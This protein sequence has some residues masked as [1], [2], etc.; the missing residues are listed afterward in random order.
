[1]RRPQ[2]GAEVFA[3]QGEIDRGLEEAELLARVVSRAFELVAQ[4]ASTRAQGAQ[5]VG[6]LNLAALVA[7]G[8]GEVLEDVWGQDVA[9]HDGEI[10]RRVLALW[11]LHQFLKQIDARVVDVT[12]APD[13]AVG[14]DIGEGDLE[15][16]DHGIAG[17]FEHF[18][19]LPQRRFLRSV[20]EVVG[21]HHRER[22]I[23]H[24]VAGGQHG[25]AEPEGLLLAHVGN[26]SKIRNLAR[27][28][29]QI[30]FA[31]FAQG[32]FKLVGDV[33]MILHRRL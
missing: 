11:L 8:G 21:K 4:K 10:R 31:A 1:V 25:M 9:A 5:T 22:F 7:G 26:R 3:L 2:S 28:A 30:V 12:F 20:D 17:A 33:E 23:A 6:E 32:G 18:N 24:Q 15:K 16:G 19:H 13:D 29:G 14:R 27:L